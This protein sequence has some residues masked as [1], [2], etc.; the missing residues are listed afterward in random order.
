VRRS[1]PSRQPPSC[2][3]LAFEHLEQREL[4]AA[5]AGMAWWSESWDSASDDGWTWTYDDAWASDTGDDQAWDDGWWIDDVSWDAA[6]GGDYSWGVDAGDDPAETWAGDTN[7]D[8]V[9]PLPADAATPPGAGVDVVITPPS[10]Q[11]EPTITV[12]AEPPVVPSDTLPIEIVDVTVPAPT[13]DEVVIDEIETS[14]DVVTDDG[15]FDVGVGVE[16]EAPI[17]VQPDVQPD[18]EIQVVGDETGNESWEF[19]TLPVDA[20]PPEPTDDAVAADEPGPDITIVTATDPVV[21]PTTVVVV[22]PVAGS[23]IVPAVVPAV[24]VPP[25][26]VTSAANRFATWSAFFFQAFGAQTG[27]ADDATTA[28]QPATGR[29]RLRLPFRPV[30]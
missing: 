10:P 16:A 23:P 1:H 15:V 18:V 7:I 24:A 26:T 21:P 20:L 30:A 28:A 25:A 3:Q 17:D 2:S 12:T 29:L 22:T 27:G 19:D 11:P 13:V 8:I 4:L 6:D 5:D 9:D 14:T